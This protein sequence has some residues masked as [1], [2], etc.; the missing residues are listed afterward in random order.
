VSAVRT[1]VAATATRA[2]GD[3]PPSPWATFFWQALRIIGAAAHAEHCFIPE[4]AQQSVN[5]AI[6][7]YSKEN[8]GRD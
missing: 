7:A 6:A 1:S 2:Q 4:L 3:A 8:N 5:E